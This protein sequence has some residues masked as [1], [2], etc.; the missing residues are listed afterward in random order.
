MATYS[1][2]EGAGCGITLKRGTDPPAYANGEPIDATA[3]M[4]MTFDAPG[5]NEACQVQND[6][7]GWGVYPADDSW[8]EVGPEDR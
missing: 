4:V 6:H 2:W 7:Y 3:V 8:E 1:I 5:W